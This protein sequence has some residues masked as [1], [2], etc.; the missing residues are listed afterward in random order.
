MRIGF[1][2]RLLPGAEAE[3]RER[4]ASVWPEMLAELKKAGASNYSI[5]LRDDD[6]FGYLEVEDFDRFRAH[7]P[8]ARSTRGGR[9]TWEMD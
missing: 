4:H 5:F 8:R 6:L 2:M 1:A 3:Y 9:P 7:M